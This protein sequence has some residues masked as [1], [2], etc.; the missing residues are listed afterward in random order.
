MLDKLNAKLEEVRK[1]KEQTAKLHK[2]LTKQLEQTE[3]DY[4]AQTGAE[5]VLLQL[6]REM[7]K[8]EK[9]EEVIT[10]ETASG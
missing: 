1:Q 2:Q 4:H 6:I 8:K 5:Q 9:A 3:A 10:D 7:P